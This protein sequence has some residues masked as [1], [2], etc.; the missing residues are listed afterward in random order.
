MARMAQL[1]SEETCGAEWFRPHAP[2][3]PQQIALVLDVDPETK[4]LRTTRPAFG[5]NI[6]ATIICP[7]TVLDTTLCVR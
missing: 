7:I 3:A 6:M 4:N 5:E 2:Q 1:Q